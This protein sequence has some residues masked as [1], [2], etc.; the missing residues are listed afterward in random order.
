MCLTPM[1]I[2]SPMWS[3]SCSDG[4]FVERTIDYNRARGWILARCLWKML[5]M[6]IRFEIWIDPGVDH[7]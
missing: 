3:R 5:G 2:S 6:P 4:A 1:P 7:K